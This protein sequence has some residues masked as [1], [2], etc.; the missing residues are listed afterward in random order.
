MRTSYLS[1]EYVSER[2]RVVQWRD[3]HYES[4]SST[5]DLSEAEYTGMVRTATLV[6]LSKVVANASINAWFSHCRLRGAF[7]DVGVVTSRVSMVRTTRRENAWGG[8]V[9]IVASR[10]MR[11]VQ[12]WGRPMLRQSKPPSEI[13]KSLRMRGEL[14]V[15]IVHIEV[16]WAGCTAPEIA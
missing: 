5:V 7:G 6:G 14:M 1:E 8:R 11:A 12:R 2:F 15:S 3:T 9:V 16:G 10:F 13:V 4:G